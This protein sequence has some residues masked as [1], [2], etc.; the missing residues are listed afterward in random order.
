[1]RDAHALLDEHAREGANRTIILMTDG[2]AN[3]KPSGWSLPSGFSWSQYTDF[4]GDGDADYT[5]SDSNVQYAFYEATQ[6]IAAGATIH[7]ISVGAGSDDNLLRA[8]AFAGGGV[9]VDIPGG[10]STAAMEAQLLEAF[11][12]IASKLPPPKLVYDAE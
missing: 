4:D 6:A 1:L 3:R 8:I 12:Q 9:F 2:L 5:T 11:A 10:S 7:T